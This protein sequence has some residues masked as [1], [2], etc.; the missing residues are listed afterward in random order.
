M[1]GGGSCVCIAVI[2]VRIYNNKKR[3]QNN[4]NIYELKTIK[5]EL[6]TIK[7]ELKTIKICVDIKVALIV[8]IITMV[9]YHRSHRGFYYRHFTIGNCITRG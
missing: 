5:K 7:K 8:I 6:K 4:K 3:T 9:K 1:Y 2:V